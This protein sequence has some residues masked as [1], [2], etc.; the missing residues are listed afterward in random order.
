MRIAAWSKEVENILFLNVCFQIF[1][2]LECQ[3][4]PIGAFTQT[5]IF[6]TFIYFLG[7]TIKVLRTY[8]TCL[9]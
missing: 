9:I 1:I 6:Y 7:K 2:L 3:D 5:H 4:L 8:G